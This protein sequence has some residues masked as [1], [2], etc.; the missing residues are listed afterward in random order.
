MNVDALGVWLATVTTTPAMEPLVELA[1]TLAAELDSDEW[2][3][4]VADQYRQT[5]ESLA[6]RLAEEGAGDGERAVVLKLSTPV[7]EQKEPK[8][9]K[10]RAGTS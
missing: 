6:G 8:P 2:T 4:P 10:S 5:L 3:A 9:R 1:R 7:G